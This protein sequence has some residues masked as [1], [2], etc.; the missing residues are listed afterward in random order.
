MSHQAYQRFA[1]YYDALYHGFVDYDGDVA[2]LE[3]LFREYMRRRP[4]SI[5]DLGCGTGNH[6]LPL[7]RRGFDVTGLDAS[8]S[9]LAVAR[10]KARAG[11]LRLRLEKADMRSFR[12][13]QKFDA[14]ISMF[15]AFGYL[16]SNSS[17]TSCLRAVRRHLADDGIFAFE[18]WHTPGVRPGHQSWMQRKR[19]G[20]EIVRFS[21]SIFDPRTSRL[22]MN[23]QFL[24]LR[25]N[26]VVDRFD[27]LHVARTYRRQEMDRFVQGAGFD[28]IAEFAVTPSRKDFRRVARDTFRIMTIARPRAQH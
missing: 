6:D 8:A 9:M 21:D 26:R 15:G 17:V 3:R 11:H 14:A 16:L 24:V 5:L 7:L 28:R 25:G 18:Y 13:G 22:A 2:F 1:E 23:F 10:R 12:L 20:L 19:G 4:Q 27:E